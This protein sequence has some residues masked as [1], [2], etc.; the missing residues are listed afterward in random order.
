MR[1]SINVATLLWPALRWQ[2]FLVNE[3]PKNGVSSP[4]VV[5][6]CII[7][8]DYEY[9]RKQKNIHLDLQ[10]YFILNLLKIT[11]QISDN[12]IIQGV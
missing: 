8:M 9:A 6:L 11:K 5:I 3:G 2:V 10:E 4:G 12:C 7:S 1:E